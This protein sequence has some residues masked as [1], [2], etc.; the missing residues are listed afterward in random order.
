LISVVLRFQLR[1]ALESWR[2]ELK[3]NFSHLLRRCHP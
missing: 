3:E 1:V 2:R